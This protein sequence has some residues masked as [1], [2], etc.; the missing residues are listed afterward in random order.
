M[1]WFQQEL[2]IWRSEMQWRIRQELFPGL[3]ICCVVVK[4]LALIMKRTK[5]VQL[6]QKFAHNVK[7]LPEKKPRTFKGWTAGHIK[8][9]IAFT[10]NYSNVG[11][12]RIGATLQRVH[13]A[14]VATKTQQWPIS[15]LLCYIC[16]CK[17][18]ESQPLLLLKRNNDTSLY[19]CAT[20]VAVNSQNH[21]HCCY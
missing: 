2:V 6:V 17:Q 20:Y 10:I 16:C 21:S 4:T 12:I 9:Y 18:S 11:N 14:I 3:V 8:L 1:L 5:R 7:N 13:I 19:C 15:V